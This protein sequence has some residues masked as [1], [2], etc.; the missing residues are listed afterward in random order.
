MADSPATVVFDLGG[1]LIDW[2][3]RHL[4][5]KLFA[6][7]TDMERFLAE[8]CTGDWNLEQ[9]RGRSLAEAT[10]I[11]VDAHPAEREM[12]EAF[13]DRWV[14]MLNGPIHGTVALLEELDAAGVPLYALTNWSAETWKVARPLYPFLDRFRGVLVSGEV[15]MVK[16]DPAIFARLCADF[17]LDP[18]RCR[19]TDDAPYNVAGAEAFGIRSHLFRG[20]DRL[21]AWLRTEGLPVA[22]A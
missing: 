2:N 13:Y 8:V 5:R 12:I 19:F 11:L 15:G 1:V 21:R 18:A 9:D 6:S 17:A 7:E 16:P 20:P 22:E 10:R 4:Y 3:P 14:E